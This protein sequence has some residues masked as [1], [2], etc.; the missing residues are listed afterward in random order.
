MLESLRLHPPVAFIEREVGAEAAAAVEATMPEDSTVI[1]FSVITGDIGRDG[2]AWTDPNEFRPD[3]FLAGGEGEL[4]GTIPGPKSKDTKMM[5]FGAGTRHCPGEGLGMMHVRCFLAALVRE[6]EWAPPG[7]ASDTI[8]MTGQIGFVVHMRT[9]LSA[10][11]TPRKWSKYFGR[12]SKAWTDP[13][14]F[15]PERFLAGKEGDGVGPVPGRKEIRMMPFGAGRRTCP[16]AGFGM[17]HVKLILASLVRDFEWESCGGVDL[18]EHDG[19]FKVMK[20]PLQARVTP[21]GRHM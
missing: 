10:R 5:P 13:E 17:L 12:D 20:T 9:P 7:K 2:K 16:G 18:T 4:V 11:I 14:E 21:V 8:D 3:R 6:F 1:R 15:R 19:F